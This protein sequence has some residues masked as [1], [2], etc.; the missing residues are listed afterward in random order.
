MPEPAPKIRLFVDAPLGPDVAI[1]LDR[2]Q[3]NYLFAVMRLAPGA[4]L[5]LFN[6]RDGEWLAEVA[7]GNKRGGV[8][9]VRRLLREQAPLPDLWLLFAPIKRARTDFIVEKAVELGVSRL[10]PVF[11]RRTASDR[12]RADRM[13]LTAREAA[14]Q[15]ERLD[16]PECREGAALDKLLADWPEDRRILF[17]DE[18]GQGG[19]H[20]RPAL[21]LLREA[22][23][24]GPPGPWAI[25]IGPEGGFADEE[26]A[27]LRVH[28]SALPAAL[29]PRILRADTAALAALSL[30][31]AACGDWHAPTP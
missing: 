24:D 6:G 30:W 14:E 23:A 3:A 11:T 5:K 12:I 1:P 18:R 13:A 27:S 7:E 26:L 10:Q 20:A 31:Q 15:C 2:D 19:G 21:D 29:G 4:P 22:V 9:A 25:L 17:C 16:L 28:P 8:L